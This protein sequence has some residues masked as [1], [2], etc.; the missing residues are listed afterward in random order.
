[1]LDAW[2]SHTLDLSPGLSNLAIRLEMPGSTHLFEAP[3]AKIWLSLQQEGVSVVTEPAVLQNFPLQLQLPATTDPSPISIIGLL[4]VVWT[5]VQE[6]RPRLMAP[7]LDTGYSGSCG[8]SMTAPQSDTPHLQLGVVLHEIYTTYYEFLRSK[9]PNCLALWHYLNIRLLVDVTVFELAAGHSGV[10]RARL[11]LQD[12]ADWC[13]TQAARRACMHAA[14]IYNAMSKRSI[15]DG[16]MLHSES[17]LFV[18]ALVL[19]L[20]VFMMQTTADTSSELPDNTAEIDAFDVLQDV[21]WRTLREDYTDVD[22]LLISS[23]PTS[24][25]ECPAI[26]ASDS[27]D[28]ATR[29]FIRDGGPLVFSG[30]KCT[31]GY[32]AAKLIL[33]EFAN[34]L[35]ETGRWKATRFCHILRI[36]SDSLLDMD[37]G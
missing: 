30:F 25:A 12:I 18:A 9:N 14:G 5:R 29:H 2:W 34:L 27:S 6:I 24:A 36:M 33:H 37:D 28:T 26:T 35:E 19:G 4:A 17:A 8:T 20:Y 13:Q 23:T 1:M 32:E 7:V 21:D 3:S 22:A 11:A 16:T 15:N 10:E 31:G